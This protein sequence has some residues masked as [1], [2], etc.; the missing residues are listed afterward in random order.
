MQFALLFGVFA[1]PTELPAAEP[2]P[3]ETVTVLVAKVQVPMGTLLNDPEKKFKTVRYVK[4]D[5][6]K[7]AVTKFAQLKGKRLT[8]S[9]VE[10][11]PVKTQYV[12]DGKNIGMFDAL[13]PAGM[14]AIA[15]KVSPATVTDGFILPGSRVDVIHT[16]RKAPDETASSVILQNLLVMAVDTSTDRD[17]TLNTV[18][19]AVKVE[20]A[21]KLRLAEAKGELSLVLRAAEDDEIAPLKQAAINAKMPY[22]PPV[23]R[24]AGQ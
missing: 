15:I 17:Q 19:L 12:T 3:M 14:R 4:G 1:L 8:H 10:D 21:K 9:L 13:M 24:R 20:D 7:D 6:P 18:T 5:E 23:R 2:R 11:Q 16:V 22:E